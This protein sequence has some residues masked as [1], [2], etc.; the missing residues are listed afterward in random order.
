MEDRLREILDHA[1]IGTGQRPICID[2]IL[3]AFEKAKGSKLT[4]DE[5]FEIQK[6]FNE[7]DDD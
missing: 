1:Y 5:S 2:H 3:N 6:V 7:A 4:Y